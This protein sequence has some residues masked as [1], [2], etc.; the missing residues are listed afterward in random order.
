MQFKFGWPRS[1]AA[2]KRLR[3]KQLRS[4][5]RR[6]LVAQGFIWSVMVTLAWGA[7]P[8]LA[9]ERVTI[10]V[11]PFEQA[12]DL[13]DLEE[14]V[15]TGELSGDLRPY[16]FLLTPDV[17]KMMSTTVELDPDAG[18]E[19]I[20]RVLDSTS[21]NQ[22]LQGLLAAIPGQNIDQLKAAIALAARYGD[23]LSIMDILRAFPDEE[24]TI[25]ASELGKLLLQFNLSSWQ[26]QS[27]SP[28]LEQELAV[29]K[30]SLQTA[31]DPAEAGPARVQQRTLTLEDRQ[32][33]RTIPVD[34]YWSDSSQGQ[35]VAI[36]HGFG[37]DRTFLT[38]LARHL[39][40][41]GITVAALDH[42]GSNVDALTAI[43]IS[44]N[45]TDFMPASEFLDR[46]QDISFMLNHL[47]ELHQQPGAL[48]GK[49]NTN[50]VTVIGHSLGGYTALALAGAK[51]NIAKLRQVCQQPSTLALSPANWLQ[52]AAT[53]LPR[54]TSDLREPR[55]AQVIALNPMVGQIFGQNGLKQVETPVLVLS[56]T[57]DTLAPALQHQLQPF[58]HLN[59]PKYLVTAIGGTHLSAADPDHL[60]I[61]LFKTLLPKERYGQD[62][63]QLHRLL[64]GTSLAFVKQLTPEA[65]AYR[66]FLTPAYAQ[67][68]STTQLP[69]RL[70]TTLPASV[71]SWLTLVNLL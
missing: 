61:A 4:G 59:P 41:H 32:R 46:P 10:R 60:N 28:L 44:A 36:S 69:L 35:L 26:N 9:A 17:R 65:S 55:V 49:L 67:S 5:L 16:S 11:G 71:A 64:K 50:Q 47:A 42:P 3:R 57:Q 62:V 58:S 15:E 43:P 38:Y 51:L 18:E 29:S 56:S 39:A 33:D 12:F 23:G 27:L 30:S 7:M 70:N 2:R 6:W 37:A 14:F 54:K 21:G 68:L 1:R 25:D 20:D 40:S 31:V 8:G 52:C 24:I 53:R 34:L 45:P 63:A 19:L 22:F 13:S 48:Q 66:P